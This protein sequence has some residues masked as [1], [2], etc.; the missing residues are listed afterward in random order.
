M[1]VLLGIPAL[2]STHLGAETTLPA[3]FAMEGMAMASLTY[4]MPRIEKINSARETRKLHKDYQRHLAFR[5]TEAIRA[6]ISR[7]Q[8]E[9]ELLNQSY[10]KKELPELM[11]A[12]RWWDRIL[13]K[14]LGGLKPLHS[15]YD[16]GETSSQVSLV[17]SQPQ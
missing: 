16:L 15:D 11:V 8:E 3:L 5:E 4:V 7:L 6:E 12:P 9:L 14:L 10:E 13:L 2:F 1:T 17:K